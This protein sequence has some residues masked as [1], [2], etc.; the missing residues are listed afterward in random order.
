[1]TRTTAT[2]NA[3]RTPRTGISVRLPWRCAR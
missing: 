1:V 3:I 2:P